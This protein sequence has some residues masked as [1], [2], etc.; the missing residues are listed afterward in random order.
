MTRPL[1]IDLELVREGGFGLL[2]QAGNLPLAP[3]P[4]TPPGGTDPLST[5]ITGEVPLAEGPI[6]AEMPTVKAGATDTATKVVSAA[7]TYERT[8]EMLGRR[9]EARNQTGTATAE[10]AASSQANPMG[11]MGQLMGMPMQMAQQAGQ[12]P[13]QMMGMAAAVPQGI[14]Q[15][16]Q[17]LMGQFGGLG[18]QLDRSGGDGTIA[19]PDELDL[20]RQ[21]AEESN[22]M[23]PDEAPYDDRDREDGAQPGQSEAQRAPTAGGSSESPSETTPPALQHRAPA[24]TRPAETDP[25]IDR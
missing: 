12:L 22:E 23:P 8:D 20:D 5:A 17:S 6:L 16:A 3:P 18:G 14:M 25:R 10:N 15:G 9:I 1:S 21:H 2:D 19:Q 7:D 24:P 11:Q 4:F 13:M